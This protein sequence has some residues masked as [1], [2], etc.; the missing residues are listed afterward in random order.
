MRVCN[1]LWIGEVLGPV[2]R[3]CLRSML[4]VGHRVRLFC[5][6]PPTDV[7]AGIELRDAAAVLPR[8]EVIRHRSGSVALFSDR[9]RYE[10]MRRDEGLW[11]DADMYL[12]RPV[13]MD[14]PYIVGE[15]ERGVANGAVLLLPA[16]SATLTRLLAV[17]REQALPPWVRGSERLKMKLGALTGRRGLVDMPWGTAGPH[18]LTAILKD[19]GL[20]NLVL[21]Q[22]T[23]YP[24]G[25]RD[26]EWIADPARP[27]EQIVSHATVGLHL[28]NHRIAHLANPPAAKG[29]F[30]ERLL[31]EGA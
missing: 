16:A 22:E 30:L 13:E 21:P 5:Y 2:Q 11:V 31:G 7:P 28:W 4:R 10:L 1:T 14:G 29:S 6:S 20:W 15:Q 27:L 18:A 8:A 26:A 3:A 17:F 23:F 25:W 12:L 19:E 9:F 24:A